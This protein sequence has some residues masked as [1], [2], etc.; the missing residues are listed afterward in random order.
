MRIGIVNDLRL[1]V[2]SLKRAVATIPGA[3]VAW[4]AEDGA[5]AVALC[6]QDRPDIVL[7]DMI[8]PVMDGVEATRRIMRSTPC[9]II[10][11]T[12]TVEGNASKVFEALG[13]GALDAV[14]TPVL[15]PDGAVN[16]EP[17]TRKIRTVSLIAGLT[18]ED[19][20]SPL[21][22]ALRPASAPA[23]APL[24]AIGASTGGP[25]ALASVLSALP[26]P[27]P[28]PI[29]IVQHVDPTFA[30]GLADWLSRETRQR[31]EIASSGDTPDPK[32]ILIAATGDHLI[33]DPARHLR[34]VVEP[35]DLVYRPSVD[36]FFD[37]IAAGKAVAGVAVILTGMGRDGAA[38]L[39]RLRSAG[40]H[41][42]A[43]DRATSVVWGMP[44]AAVEFG[45]AT[46]TL[47]IQGIAGAI[48]LHMAARTPAAPGS[49]GSR[50]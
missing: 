9:P 32:R 10:V 40:W 42:I 17:L 37:S 34:Y 14:A 18:P 4:V 22:P 28:W 30:Q 20:R 48:S 8:M 2:E 41:T 39:G 1:A 15:A 46:E 13:A 45:A 36:V 11:V 25:Q 31:V 50:L 47:P 3:T 38:G 43:Q 24:V 27:A 49:A 21:L 12:A 33:L 44:G 19:A 26:R 16:A 5:K 7:M 23:V 35:K 29:V 6:A